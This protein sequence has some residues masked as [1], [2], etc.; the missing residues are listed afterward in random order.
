MQY[1]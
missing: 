1:D